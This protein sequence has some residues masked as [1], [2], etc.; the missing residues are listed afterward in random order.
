MA[1]TFDLLL[2]GGTVLNPAVVEGQ[3][4]GAIA[5]GIGA[6][7]SSAALVLALVLIHLINETARHAGHAAP[8]HRRIEPPLHAPLSGEK[9]ATSA[10][11]S[12][13]NST[14]VSVP[15]VGR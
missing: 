15:E 5:Q 6:V 11:M 9:I 8:G 3:V 12:A 7:M 1:D 10:R 2:T 14:A 13:G 4:I